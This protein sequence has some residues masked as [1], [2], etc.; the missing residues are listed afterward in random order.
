MLK[1]IGLSRN[2]TLVIRFQIL[3]FLLLK[4]LDVHEVIPMRLPMTP[5]VRKKNL[6]RVSQC[7]FSQEVGGG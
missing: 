3:I 4:F 1:K 2:A 7:C 5:Y 6:N